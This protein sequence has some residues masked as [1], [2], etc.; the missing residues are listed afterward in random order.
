MGRKVAIGL[1]HELSQGGL[2]PVLKGNIGENSECLPGSIG[3]G[4]NSQFP[5]D[6]F[7]VIDKSLCHSE[8]ML[9]HS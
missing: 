8:R 4:Y 6:Q 5:S 7:L 9:F 3:I 1:G 2:E